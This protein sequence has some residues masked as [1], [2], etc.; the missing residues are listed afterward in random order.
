MVDKTQVDTK[1]EKNVKLGKC[2][3]SEKQVNDKNT[4][5]K[6]SLT[7]KEKQSDPHTETEK[8][9]KTDIRTAKNR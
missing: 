8:H 5:I 4:P 1:T 7:E 6:R 9:R 2:P 3:C